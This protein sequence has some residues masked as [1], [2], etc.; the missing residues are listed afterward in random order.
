MIWTCLYCVFRIKIRLLNIERGPA[1]FLPIFETLHSMMTLNERF[2]HARQF[3]GVL[4]I[5][6]QHH[7]STTQGLE[8]GEGR[9][10]MV[11]DEKEREQTE[12]IVVDPF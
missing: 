8:Q 12:D 9:E 3:R 10:K 2:E 7:L 4:A 11:D 6:F 1:G 5:T